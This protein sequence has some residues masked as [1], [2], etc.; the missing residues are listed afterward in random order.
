MADVTLPVIGK[1]KK[2]VVV[3]VGV[4]VVAIAGFMIYRSKKAKS[5]AATAGTTPSSNSATASNSYGYGTGPGAYPQGYYGYGE[6]QGYYGYGAL[7]SGSYGSYPGYYGYGTPTPPIESIATNAQWAQAAETQLGQ[8]QYDPHTVTNALGAYLTGAPLT[9]NEVDIARAA[10]ALEG[11]PPQPGTNGYPPAFHHTGT[12]GG[13]AGGGHPKSV[14]VTVPDVLGLPFRQANKKVRDAGLK[15]QQD[16]TGHVIQE[17]PIAG[18]RVDKG[19]TVNLVGV[20]QRK[21][22]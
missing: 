19:S 4:G 16:G 11:Y 15:V 22:T 12:P 9:N 1:Q 5:S 10:I 2:G 18:S 8:E 21:T 20:T 13:G 7:G 6:T 14:K 3:G 17:S